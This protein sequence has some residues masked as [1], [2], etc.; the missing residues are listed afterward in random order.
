MPKPKSR[1][2][3]LIVVK[4]IFCMQLSL[5]RHKFKVLPMETISFQCL[6]FDLRNS[7]WQ[8][9]SVSMFAVDVNK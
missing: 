5:S 8:S 3:T 7:D 6:C 9:L 1:V 4:P 2:H